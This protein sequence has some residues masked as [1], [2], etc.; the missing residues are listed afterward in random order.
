MRLVCP[1]RPLEPWLEP[2]LLAGH[3]LGLAPLS[4][5]AGGGVRPSLGPSLGWRLYS[6][7]LAALLAGAV[8]AAMYNTTPRGSK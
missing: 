2:W 6:G 5:V 3:V 7:T 4:R 1:R 8:G